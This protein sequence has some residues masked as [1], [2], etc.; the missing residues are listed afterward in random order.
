MQSRN[1]ATKRLQKEIEELAK[2]PSTEFH[3]CPQEDDIFDWHFTVAGPKDTEYEG[4]VYH[5]RIIFPAEYP[6]KPPSVIFLTP[7]G[8]FQLHTKICLS[9]TGYHPEHW[10]PA[11]GVRTALLALISFFP[12]NDT[13]SI[14]S[15]NVSLEERKR[16]ASLSRS[17]KCDVC[18]KSNY[19]LLYK[20]NHDL[21]SSK[22][23]SSNNTIL[24]IFLIILS[25]LIAASS[26]LRNK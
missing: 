24:F 19:Q 17:W 16:L 4:G 5:G 7:N 25:C 10:Q 20:T 26:L 2:E 14:G 3:A 22:P 12:T 21:E 18:C 8:R 6:F 23:A 11:W 9:I 1:P 13:A 15:L